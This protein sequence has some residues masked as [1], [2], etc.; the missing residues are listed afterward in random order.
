MTETAAVM[1]IMHV[2]VKKKKQEKL[3]HM[4]FKRLNYVTV[5]HV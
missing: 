4:Y 2:A 5:I 1:Q 3:V